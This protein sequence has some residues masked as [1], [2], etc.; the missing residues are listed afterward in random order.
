[1]EFYDDRPPITPLGD[2]LPV[3]QP[4]NRGEQVPPPAFDQIRA[5]RPIFRN[6][7]LARTGQNPRN[8]SNIIKIIL[9]FV[10][11]ILLAI[12]AK[13]TYE[14]VFAGHSYNRVSSSSGSLNNQG[15]DPVV[16]RLLR[17][18]DNFLGK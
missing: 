18:I 5:N 2:R 6:P 8:G 15:T 3:P 10:G 11:M 12:W 1:M 9:I 14:T 16:D 4:Q 13:N 17:A 7:H